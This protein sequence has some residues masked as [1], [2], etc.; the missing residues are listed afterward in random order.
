MSGSRGRRY[1]I[2]VENTLKHLLNCEGEGIPATRASVA[3]VLRRGDAAVTQLLS[4][5]QQRGLVLARGHGDSGVALHLTASGRTYATHVLRAHRLWE[6]FLAERTGLGPS[7]WHRDADRREHVSTEAEVREL[8]RSLGYPRFDPHGD[9][10]PEEGE[11]LHPLR[12]RPLSSLTGGATCQVVHIEDE[13]TDV[14]ARVVAAGIEVGSIIEVVAAGRDA[15]CY[16]LG[17]RTLELAAIVAANVGVQP[18]ESHEHTTAA[19]LGDLPVGAAAEVRELS[20]G[21]RGLRRRRL[22]DLGF[23]RG[24]AVAV[25]FAGASGDPTAFQ[26]RGTVISLRNADA[27]QIL[28]DPL[29]S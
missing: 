15:V 14:Y 4:E 8:A 16:R 29:P 3:G 13:P 27:A 22:L 17:D 28:V 7:R 2:R 10:I 19:T 11:A 18:L 26:I 6:R 24:A 20:G 1:R 25:L 23:T 12:Q 5:L 21:C 9:P